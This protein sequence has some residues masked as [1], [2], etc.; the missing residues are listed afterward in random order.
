MTGHKANFFHTPDKVLMRILALV[1]TYNVLRN[2]ARVFK[3]FY[4]LKKDLD[5]YRSTPFTN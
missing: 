3:N 4:L 2:V 5:V 1:P